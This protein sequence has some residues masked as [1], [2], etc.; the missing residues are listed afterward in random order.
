M[1]FMGD[2]FVTFQGQEVSRKD[3]KEQRHPAYS[4]Q[5]CSFA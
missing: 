3:A 1:I 5:L 4:L 2:I